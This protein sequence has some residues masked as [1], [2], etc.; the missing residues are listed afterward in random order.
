MWP[1]QAS[2]SAI[3]S[4]CSAV[5][6]EPMAARRTSRRTSCSPANGRRLAGAQGVDHLRD[7]GQFAR[8]VLGVGG[9]LDLPGQLL[10]Q[11]RGGVAGQQVAD[12]V[13]FQQ[14]QRVRVHNDES[15]DRLLV[16]QVSN[17]SRPCRDRLETC[18]T[19]NKSLDLAIRSMRSAFGHARNVLRFASSTA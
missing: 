5:S 2:V 10:A 19:S 14:F 18:P 8:I 1:V 16:G 12:L 4:S 11:R 13:E 15:K 7:Q 6:I 9:R 3:S 17:L